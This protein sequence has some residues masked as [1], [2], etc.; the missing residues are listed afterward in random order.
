[1]T[2]RVLGFSLLFLFGLL[3]AAAPAARAADNPDAFLGIWLN[4]E[5][6]G[7]VQIFK[8]G[9]KYFGRVVWMKAPLTP[10]GKPQNDA[11]NPDKAKSLLPVK[12]MVVMR[13]FKYT[14]NSKWEGGR[15][16]DPNN[17]SDYT[18]EITMV[19]PNT[20]KVR[21][22]IGISLFGRTEV[23]KRTPMPAN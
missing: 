4:G 15:I 10:E 2:K 9:E 18:C 20:L 19:N 6:T 7:L 1:M 12:G 13:D 5:G 14:G 23:W 3:L 8:K 21:G 22:F 17:G 11:N 16:Y